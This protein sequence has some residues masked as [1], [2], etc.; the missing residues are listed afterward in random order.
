[1]RR[2]AGSRALLVMY[3]G[4]LT[5]ERYFVTDDATSLLPAAL[6]AR[7]LAAMAVGLA[8]ADGRIASLD[9]PVARYLPEWDD[10]AA[11]SHHHP[12]APGGNQRAGNRRRHPRPAVSLA[13]GRSCGP[14]GVRDLQGRAHVVRQRFRIE[15]TRLPAGA[16]AR[17]LLQPVAGQYA[18][19]CSHRRT[20]HRHCHSKR[21]S[22]IACG[23]WWVPA[24]HNC[25]STGAPA[26]PRR[27]AAGARR[28]ATCCAC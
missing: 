14:A 5:I 11:W 24:A 15:R 9:S 25:S 20:R 13:L 21:M 17:R 8:L 6:V 2:A 3:R 10:E 4:R 1:M 18:A 23:A 28:H 27:T 22:T 12:A 16:R 26:C 19:R 7:P